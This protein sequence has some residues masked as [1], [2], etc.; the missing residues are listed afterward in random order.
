[1]DLNYNT[2]KRLSPIERIEASIEAAPNNT[3][4]STSFGIQSAAMLHMVT[5]IKNDIPVIFIDTGYMFPETYNFADFLIKKLKI[6]V[7]VYRSD[8]S[9]AWQECRYGRL[10]EKDKKHMELYNKINKVDPMSKAIQDFQAEFWISGIR[11]EQSENRSNKTV[12]EKLDNYQKIY[13]IL[14]WNN[15]DVHNYLKKN[16]LPYHPLWQK[17]YVSVGDHHSTKSL[18]EVDD[19]LETRNN[20]HS[21]ECGLHE[22]K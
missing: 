5:S 20:G 1:M 12:I 6:N 3:I 19:E 4:V 15:R 7:F 9:P 22:T 14:D 18:H 8:I 16:N 11:K 17:G 10:W 21:R 2:F 13:P